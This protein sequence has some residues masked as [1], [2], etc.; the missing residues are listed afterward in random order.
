MRIFAKYAKYAAMHDRYEPVS[1]CSKRWAGQ[2]DLHSCLMSEMLIGTNGRRAARP[3]LSACLQTWREIRVSGVVTRQNAARVFITAHGLPGP[4]VRPW[5]AAKC[6]ASRD[7]LLISC[8]HVTHQRPHSR[9][10]P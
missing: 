4:N 3:V 1:L 2:L 8:T 10:F 7:L 5:L 9:Y 6:R